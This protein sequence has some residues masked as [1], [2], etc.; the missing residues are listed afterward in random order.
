MIALVAAAAL[1]LAGD[2]P[3]DVDPFI[4]TGGGDAAHPISVGPGN[5]F[6][7]AVVPWGMV[8]PSPH[9]D[10]A[11]PSGYRFGAP[12]PSTIEGFGHVH[13]SGVGCPDL[14]NI[15]VAAIT[16]GGRAD[17]Y[18]SRYTN[19]RAH[20]GYYAVELTRFGV[21]V[22]LTASTRVGVTRLTWPRARGPLRVVVDAAQSLAPPTG[23]QARVV[24]PT[25]PMTE[26]EG[27]STSGGFCAQGNRQTVYFVARFDRA[28]RDGGSDG[29]VAWA[30]FDADGAPLTVAVGVSWVSIA[31]ARLNLDAEW[32]ARSFDDV[33]RR[34]EAAWTRELAKLRV[35]GGSADERRIFHTAHYHMLLHPS[36]ISDVNGD[37]P[38][39]GRERVG[40]AVGYTRYS[41]F[42]LWDTYRLL[43]PFL[44]LVHPDRQ[45]DMVRT[46]IEMYRERGWLPKWELAGNETHVMVGDPAVIVVADTWLRGLRDFD[47]ATAWEAIR[48]HVDT[49][50]GNDARPGS[51]SYLR[52]GY[53]PVDDGGDW[54][55]GAV[56]TTLEYALAD[57]AAAQ[58][59]RALG[60]A[61]IAGT[62]S[63]RAL[64]YRRL[65]DGGV[66]RPRRRDGSWL[67]PFDPHATCCDKPWAESGGPGF[68]EGSAAQY[69]F[70]VPHDVAGLIARLGGDAQFSARL[71]RLFDERGFTLGNEHDQ[72]LPWLFTFVDGE[73]WRT[74]QLVPALAAQF[75]VGPDGLPGNDD[76][77]ALS[78]W[79]LWSALGLYP[80]CPA[81]N[82]YEIGSPRF[83]RVEIA[84]DP[85]FW[86]GRRFVVERDGDGRF[87]DGVELDGEPRRGL[88]ID[89]ARVVGGGVLRLHMRG[90][91]CAK[92]K[93]AARRS[94]SR[95]SSPSSGPAAAPAP[96][97]AGRSPG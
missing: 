32:A 40:N 61:R 31:N 87:V 24:S 27:A 48:K 25:E 41:V 65:L 28:A 16:G 33:R 42:S 58:L 92:T 90:A 74:Q 20:P 94:P 93:Q 6:P 7:G 81:S 53:I 77:G 4:G 37:Y 70:F 26:I 59:A 86:P 51:A 67:Q 22:E 21:A 72:A 95:C 17:D 60:H 34:A 10:R 30:R 73:A 68:V 84:L 47:V 19:E 80:S 1:A 63:S 3:F 12:T 46:M 23:G 62:L 15:V 82:R 43:H 50:A 57:W 5:T 8:S 45:L 36:V 97:A 76:A 13:L 75:R 91:P 52:R 64:A 9:D 69:T 18:G 78:A 2:N 89:H 71:Q 88:H 55:F 14:G 44:T 29:A 56:S 38:A 85:R 11:A 66:V 49:G 79:W 39:M 35:D 54:I 83:R 96:P